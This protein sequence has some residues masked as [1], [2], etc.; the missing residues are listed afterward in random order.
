MNLQ[1]IFRKQ[2][3]GSTLG[4]WLSI[5][6]VVVAGSVILNFVRI[7]KTNRSYLKEV[8]ETGYIE[9]T[10]VAVVQEMR[11]ENTADSPNEAEWGQIE[12]GLSQCMAKEANKYLLSGDPYLDARANKKS[13]QL[14]AAQFLKACG[15]IE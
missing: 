12:Q 9:K 4:R 10:A 13:P 3:S 1:N 8:I 15:A 2:L 14:L 7:E 11:K 6:F 5:F